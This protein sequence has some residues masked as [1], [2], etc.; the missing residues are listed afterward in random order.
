MPEL[1]SSFWG[2]WIIVLTVGSLLVLV[3]LVL[4]VYFFDRQPDD[5]AEVV[6]DE[7]L[8]E[9]NHPA[10][11]WWFWL[12]VVLLVI[13]V[14]YLLLYPGLGRYRGTLGWSQGHQLAHSEQRY[15]DEFAA[16]HATL[17][18]QSLSELAQNHL[19]MD[20]ALSL[21]RVHCG[22]CHGEDAGGVAGYAPNLTDA[23][24]QWGQRDEEILAS[25][26]AGRQAAMPPWR[27]ALGDDSVTVLAD[28]LKVIG[29]QAADGPQYEQAAATF[30]GS[31]SVCHGASGEGKPAL[32]APD[33]TDGYWLYGS[34]V[35]DI[36]HSIARGRQGRMPAHADRL[37]E[38]Q[39]RLL[40][41]WLVSRSGSTL[42]ESPI[43]SVRD[44]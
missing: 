14:V 31:C 9:G 8:R 24:W 15:A 34:S 7:T 26:T 11:L 18:G 33:L 28:Y 35:D 6:W 1:P 2:S 25:I 23:A 44:K 43:Q 39:I 10:P 38:V 16:P 42:P 12:I 30:A 32:G 29:T 19:A 17:L 13:S 41:A 3:G 21:F 40:A 5:H 22:T 20:A 4:S 27:M 37:S 36:A